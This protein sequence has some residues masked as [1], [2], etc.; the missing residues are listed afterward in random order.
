MF[1]T[2]LAEV[3]LGVSER[4]ALWALPN[5]ECVG[6]CLLAFMERGGALLLTQLLKGLRGRK[7]VGRQG[8]LAEQRF[9]S[10]GDQ[11]GGGSSQK[12]LES[13]VLS[14][15][16]CL[17]SGFVLWVLDGA[18]NIK[19]YHGLQTVYK[20]RL[21]QFLHLLHSLPSLYFSS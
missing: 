8:S 6:A 1:G 17:L 2:S 15:L 9:L 11:P 19:C 4:S 12:E 13:S 3:L 14:A 10:G 18:R 21:D 7:C 16:C 20:N 5:S